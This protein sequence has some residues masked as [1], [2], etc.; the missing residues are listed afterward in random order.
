MDILLALLIVIIF[1]ICGFA[2]YC[3]IW[4]FHDLHMMLVVQDNVVVPVNESSSI[5]EE[6]YIV[7]IQPTREIVL[8]I[9]K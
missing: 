4:A 8:G 5:N 7:F 6:K 9:S 3:F 1:V 2:I